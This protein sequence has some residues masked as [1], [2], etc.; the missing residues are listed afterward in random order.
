MWSLNQAIAARDLARQYGVKGLYYGPAGCGKT[1]LINTAP[2]PIL[3]AVENGL[4]SMRHSGVPTCN[5]INSVTALDGFLDWCEKSHEAKGF[6]TI[7][8]DSGS[9]LAELF[10]REE[11][12]KTTARGNKPDGKAAY[13]EMARRTYA[14]IYRL[15]ALKEKH[16]Y[17]ICKQ[18]TATVDG[19]EM[20]VPYFPG[21]D[22]Y[23]TVPGLFDNIVQLTTIS[24]PQG[25]L[26]ALR[27]R[28]NFVTLARNRT[29]NLNEFE[30]RDLA[31]LFNKAVS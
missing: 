12:S 1:P 6:D 24:T 5:A 18:G 17:M 31:A 26:D 10:L 28:G 15:W 3:C 16:V 22:L 14:R 11:M 20:T 13:G 8:F 4:G 21:K 19:V 9:F 25:P 27:C 29:G 7:G 30:P 23:S 2:R